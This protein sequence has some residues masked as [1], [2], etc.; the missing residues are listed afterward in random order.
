M[1]R[2]VEEQE[3]P[4]IHVVYDRKRRIYAV[5]FEDTTGDIIPLESQKLVKAFEK[6]KKVVLDGYREAQG[7]EIDYL[8]K[9]YLGAEPVTEEELEK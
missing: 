3:P 9:T 5:F 6:L 2:R 1:K 4:C 8:A 7:D